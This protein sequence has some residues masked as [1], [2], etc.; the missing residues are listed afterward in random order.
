MNLFLTGT[1]PLPDGSHVDIE[2][3]FTATFVPYVGGPSSQPPSGTNPS[4]TPPSSTPPS[5]TPPSSTPPS[6]LP[7]SS[8]PPSSLPPSGVGPSSV[9]PSGNPSGGG[10][11]PTPVGFYVV[12]QQ[13]YKNGQL[14][15]PT[16]G[17][18]IIFC[19]KADG[20]GPAWPSDMGARAGKL[21]AGAGKGLNTARLLFFTGGAGDGPPLTNGKP[22]SPTFIGQTIDATYAAGVI[23]DVAL[24]GGKDIA[25]W[26][27]ADMKAVLIPRQNKIGALHIVGEAYETDINAWVTRAKSWI[28]RTRAAGYTAPITIMPPN[29]G[30]NLKATLDR[31]AE[32]IASDPL[33]NTFMGWQAY[34]SGTLDNTTDFYQK[35][36]GMSLRQAFQ[37]VKN[38]AFHIQVGL[39]SEV[40]DLTIGRNTLDH[41]AQCNSLGLPYLWWSHNS[42]SPLWFGFDPGSP[43]GGSQWNNST[44]TAGQELATGANGIDKSTRAALG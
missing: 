24:S 38:C 28:S 37:A 5:S 44:L 19:D 4:S 9:P 2:V 15:P 22:C 18:E 11:N 16:R 26:E 33:K 7:P 43:Y 1:I 42:S 36:S 34:W 21:S 10:D 31:G 17:I 23:P 14:L 8:Q 30:R 3:P 27:R 35:L 40:P 6:S 32:I 13:L 39:C 20:T 29:G 25:Q 12:G 41:Q